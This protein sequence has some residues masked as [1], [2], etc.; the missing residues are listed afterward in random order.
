LRIYFQGYGSIACPL[1]LIRGKRSAR[2]QQE[3]IEEQR[4]ELQNKIRTLKNLVTKILFP[5]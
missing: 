3:T 1:S 5:R 4:Q 2:V